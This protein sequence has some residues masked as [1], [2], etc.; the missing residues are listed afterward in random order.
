VQQLLV[1]LARENS[2]WATSAARQRC[3]A[4]VTQQARNLL[5][6]PDPTAQLTILGEDDRGA[7]HR[8]DLLGGLHHKYRQTA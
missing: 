3:S 2:T 1:R 8:R 5:Q 6:P 4:W 7:V